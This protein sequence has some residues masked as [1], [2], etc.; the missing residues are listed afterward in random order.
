MPPEDG[1]RPLALCRGRF[2]FVF[3]IGR[4]ISLTAFAVFL[5]TAYKYSI[6]VPCVNKNLKVFFGTFD[7]LFIGVWCYLTIFHLLASTHAACF[8]RFS[9]SHAM[10]QRG[11]WCADCLPRW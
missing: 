1:D 8:G 3:F 9:V 4:L 2:L 7:P 11:V 5:L 10:N 6:S